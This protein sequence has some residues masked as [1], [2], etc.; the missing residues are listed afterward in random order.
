MIVRHFGLGVGLPLAVLA[1]ALVPAN[2]Q[3]HFRVVTELYG[4][5]GWRR[6]PGCLLHR[7]GLRQRP[8][9]VAA[10][11]RRQ[12]SYTCYIVVGAITR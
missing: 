10:P 8:S 12:Y 3:V 1:I 5:G 11:D 6:I 9:R 7:R 2:A 4:A